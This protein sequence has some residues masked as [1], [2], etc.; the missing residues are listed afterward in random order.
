MPEDL[1]KPLLAYVRRQLDDDTDD[2]ATL[3]RQSY[4]AFVLAIAGTP[5]RTSLSRLTELAKLTNQLEDDMQHCMRSDASLMLSCAWAMAGRHDLAEQMFPDTLPVPR[6]K[7]E[8]ANNIGSPIRD[9]ALLIYTARQSIRPTD[10]R[11]PALVQEA[12]A[13]SGLHE[14]WD[15]QE[16]AFATLAIGKYLE[17]RSKRLPPFRRGDAIGRA[18]RTPGGPPPAAAA[19]DWPAIRPDQARRSLHLPVNVTGVAPPMPRHTSRGCNPACRSRR[20][21]ML[22]TAS[23][24]IANISLPPAPRFLRTASP[25]AS[26][27][28]SASRSPPRRASKT[29]SSKISSPPAWKPEN[30]APENLRRPARMRRTRT[31]TPTTQK[32]SRR[33]AP[34]FDNLPA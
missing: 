13:D 21:P 25:P 5:D 32:R 14:T 2:A 17:G 31:M 15:T 3:E 16:C 19:S 33:P 12:L 26:S 7:R 22:S 1:Y 30:D 9:R 29:W 23:R 24:S 28:A 11:L 8:T 10:P 18:R 4:A 27:S 20:P 34:V 6:A